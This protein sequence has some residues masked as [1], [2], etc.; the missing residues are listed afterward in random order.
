[1]FRYFRLFLGETAEGSP[2]GLASASGHRA[3]GDL[4]AA[5][6]SDPLLV[7]QVCDR[8]LQLFRPVVK[9]KNID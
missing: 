7:S 9:I 3:E 4:D 5:L 1:M 6:T 8:I 2:K